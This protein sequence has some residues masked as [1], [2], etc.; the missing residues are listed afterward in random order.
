MYWHFPTI[1][2]HL[3]AVLAIFEVDFIKSSTS[4]RFCNKI[5]LI[6]FIKVLKKW[7]YLLYFQKKGKYLFVPYLLTSMNKIQLNGLKFVNIAFTFFDQ[8]AKGLHGPIS[9][10]H[11]LKFLF[12]S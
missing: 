7:G 6:I 9:S 4:Y 10:F 8:R 11:T 2:I 3:V 5:L 1:L 12:L